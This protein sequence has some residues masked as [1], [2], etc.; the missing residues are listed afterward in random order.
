MERKVFFRYYIPALEEALRY[1]KQIEYESIGPDMFIDDNEIR[2]K[3]DQFENEHF[4][5]FEKFFS[6]VSLYFDAITHNFNHIKG[7]SIEILKLDILREIKIL[8]N[9]Y[10]DN[11]L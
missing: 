2:N 5:E 7:K 8:K 4:K 9:I 1:E 3:L 10:Y 6:L 11:D